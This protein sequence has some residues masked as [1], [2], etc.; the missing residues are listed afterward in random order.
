MNTLPILVDVDGVVLDFVG[1]LCSKLNAH[2]DLSHTDGYNPRDFREYDLRET[3][4]PVSMNLVSQWSKDGTLCDAREAYPDARKWLQTLQAL[5]PV[6]FLTA[7]GPGDWNRK[8]TDF[9]VRYVSSATVIISAPHDKPS[10][11]GRTLIED[12]PATAEAWAEAQG[13]VS[14]LLDRPWN[15]SAK[16][17]P[18]VLRAR[19]YMHA[20]SIV[21]EL[22]L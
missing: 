21:R 11:A 18:R 5:A 16:L 2:Y 4:N 17:S 10:V 8:S 12:F 14:V 19:N 6:Q 15:H 20:T 22:C 3:L 7:G 9:L 13:T 1:A